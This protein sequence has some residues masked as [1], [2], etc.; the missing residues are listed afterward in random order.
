MNAT[1]PSYQVEQ[2]GDAKA[3]V[4]PAVRRP[5]TSWA[6]LT[7]VPLH[8]FP[9]RDEIL[10]QYLPFQPGMDVAEVGLGTGF[11]SC[12]LAGQARSYTGIDVSAA[13]VERLKAEL[14]HLKN[15]EFVCA[16]LAQPDVPN[17]VVKRFDV[18]YGLDVFEY[19]PSPE[20][21]LQNL[22]NLLQSGGM[23]LLSYPNVP[24]PRGDGVTWFEQKATLE[25]LIAA[26]GFRRWEIT[27]LRLRPWAGKVFGLLHEWPIGLY[28][29]RHRAERATEERPQIYEDTWAFQKGQRLNR[30]RSVLHGSWAVL[31]ALMRMFGP[32]YESREVSGDQT[33]LGRQLLIRA[34]K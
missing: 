8:D 18:V 19:V 30:Y 31:S 22:A 33:M 13:T 20:I 9:V 29:S 6:L 10:F 4:K 26:A 11:T 32:V 1:A 23:M 27:E 24:P 5:R 7:Q 34:W 12:W 21:C 3:G 28:R 15:A 14:R 2:Q 17:L 16:D 25:G